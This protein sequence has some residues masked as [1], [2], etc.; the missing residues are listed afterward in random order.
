MTKLLIVDD[1][2]IIRERLKS[3]LALDGYESFSAGDGKE[4]LQVFH[5]EEPQLV[6]LDIKMPGMDGIEVLKRM[7]QTAIRSE[8]IMMTGH[9]GLETAIDAM[10]YGAFD[11]I[12]KPV[13]YSELEIAIGRAVA[14]MEVEEA[15]VRA[16]DDWEKTF[17]AM[18]DLIMIVDREHRVV[19]VNRAMT[20]KLGKDLTGLVCHEQVHGTSVPHPFCP[21]A[22]LLEDGKEHSTEFYEQ[23]LGGHFQLTVSPLRDQDGTIIGSVHVARDITERKKAEDVLRESQKRAE[24]AN[25][26]KSQFS[27][28]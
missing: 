26:A 10:K 6:I 8:V 16:R 11:Y 1:D 17:N 15:L 3:L 4:G 19:K 23:R 21:H 20:E 24:A 27:P 2:T 5:Q 14:K 18:S 12:P 25:E 9:G 28:T 7:K 22:S 13:D